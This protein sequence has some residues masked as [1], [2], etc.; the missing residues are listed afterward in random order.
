MDALDL[1][2]RR[3]CLGPRKLPQCKVLTDTTAFHGKNGRRV[4]VSGQLLGVHSLST[5]T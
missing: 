3:A 1:T 2:A 4:K 5:G